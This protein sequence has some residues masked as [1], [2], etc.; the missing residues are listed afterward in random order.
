MA[1]FIGSLNKTLKNT[2]RALRYSKTVLIFNIEFDFKRLRISSFLKNSKKRANLSILANKGPSMINGILSVALIPSP[3]ML[4]ISNSD[5]LILTSLPFKK[6]SATFLFSD[7]VGLFK[8]I[9][10]TIN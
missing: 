8:V 1:A 9:L 3:K 7:P 5:F 10:S 2:S 4:P 6:L